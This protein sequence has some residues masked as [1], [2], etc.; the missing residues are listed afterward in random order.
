MSADRFLSCPVFSVFCECFDTCSREYEFSQSWSGIMLSSSLDNN[1][2]GDNIQDISGSL[3]GD[4][5]VAS[6]NF[7]YSEFPLAFAHEFHGSR[8]VTI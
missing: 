6:N 7:Q 3:C 4:D 2:L 5:T 1:M 8:R